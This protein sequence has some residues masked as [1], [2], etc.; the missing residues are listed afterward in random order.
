MDATIPDIVR[1]NLRGAT[2]PWPIPAD[3]DVDD[4]AGETAREL[5]RKGAGMAR[6]ASILGEM[7]FA[8]PAGGTLRPCHVWRLLNRSEPSKKAA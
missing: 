2:M 1:I 4:R 7:G 3:L 5:R 8:A 6:I